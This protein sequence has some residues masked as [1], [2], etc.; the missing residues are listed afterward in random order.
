MLG[1]TMSVAVIRISDRQNRVSSLHSWDLGKKMGG[2]FLL[3]FMFSCCWQA[4]VGK[5]RKDTLDI[6][7]VSS[8]LPKYLY[9]ATHITNSS[10][11]IS[12][13]ESNS[14]SPSS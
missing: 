5:R 10:P 13:N 12:H 9:H 6:F 7:I 11:I 2:M 1:R 4:G 8:Y 3:S 14:N